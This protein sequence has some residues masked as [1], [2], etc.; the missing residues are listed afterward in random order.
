MW[1]IEPTKGFSNIWPGDVVFDTTWLIFKLV[2]DIIKENI[3]TNFQEFWT[4]NVAS[5]AYT[6]FFQDLT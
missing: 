4:E 2:Q 1:H 5:R 3:L 6:K